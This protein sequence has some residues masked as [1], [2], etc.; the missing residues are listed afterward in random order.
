MVNEKKD[1]DLVQHF[2]KLI[3]KDLKPLTSMLSEQVT[4]LKTFSRF[5]PN[6]LSLSVNSAINKVSLLYRLEDSSV[7]D[8]EV[9]STI[10]QTLN[11]MKVY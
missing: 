9:V 10:S 11:E 2:R 8:E 5:F 4:F 6:M 1:V 3:L 7:V